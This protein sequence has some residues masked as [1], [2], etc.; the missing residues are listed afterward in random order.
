MA[1]RSRLRR[2]Y[3]PCPLG[4]VLALGRPSFPDQPNGAA[5]RFRRKCNDPDGSPLENRYLPCG[6]FLPS[7]TFPSGP[8]GRVCGPAA[9]SKYECMLD[10]KRLEVAIRLNVVCWTIR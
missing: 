5:E 1:S 10:A 7:R 4:G 3:G 8:R 2:L 9:E 6:L